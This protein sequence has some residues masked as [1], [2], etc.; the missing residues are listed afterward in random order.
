M[1]YIRRAVNK[2]S[3]TQCSQDIFTQAKP[4]PLAYD[5]LAYSHDSH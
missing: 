1:A 4:A 5:R 2:M 3:V